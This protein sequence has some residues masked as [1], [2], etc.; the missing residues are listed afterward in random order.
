MRALTWLALWCAVTALPSCGQTTTPTQGDGGELQEIAFVREDATTARIWLVKEDGSAPR[1]LTTPLSGQRHLDPRWSPDGTLLAYRVLEASGSEL[2]IISADGSG[3]HLVTNTGFQCVHGEPHWSPD[4]LRIAYTETCAGESRSLVID[5]EGSN[6]IELAPAL[7]PAGAYTEW[8]LDGRELAGSRR[9]SSADSLVI[10]ASDGSSFAEPAEL[11]K[12]PTAYLGYPGPFAYVPASLQWSPDGVHFSWSVVTKEPSLDAV[13]VIDADGT[14]H[15]VRAPG[16]AAGAWSAD[17]QTL[18]YV[19]GQE[20]SFCACSRTLRLMRADGTGMKVLLD[21][22]TLLPSE[23]TWSPDGREI[24]FVGNQGPPP[25]S[26]E[27][28]TEGIYAINLDGSG[29][30]AVTRAGTYDHSPRWKPE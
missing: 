16:G 11:G 25:G 14:S 27:G 7:V 17:G 3:E 1:A 9:A 10:V 30:R 26:G 18:A 15:G 29:L 19:I 2:A 22:A 8:S 4:G 23:P 6:R 5:Q 20:V 13:V 21:D 28:L 24:A 12:D